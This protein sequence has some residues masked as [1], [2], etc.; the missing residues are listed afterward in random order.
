[1]W[2]QR[3]KKDGLDFAR[4]ADF[5]ILSYAAQMETFQEFARRS[6][7]DLKNYD[8]TQDA[9]LGSYFSEMAKRYR[10]FR[11]AD[12]KQTSLGLNPL[13]QQWEYGWSEGVCDYMNKVSDWIRRLTGACLVDS[14]R[15]S[16]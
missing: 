14:N 12:G 13:F 4:Q 2:F 1:M 9:I 16:A 7:G 3:G 6:N 10:L 8:P 5:D 11:F 15:K